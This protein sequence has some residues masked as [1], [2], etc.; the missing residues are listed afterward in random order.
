M[1]HS[2]L[3][4]FDFDGTLYPFAPYDSEE[5]LMLLASRRRGR[6]IQARAKRAVLKDMAGKSPLEEFDRNFLRYAK[7]TDGA[8]LEEDVDII[9]KPCAKEAYASLKTLSEHA[10]IIVLSAGTTDLSRLFLKRFDV[11]QCITGYYGKHLLFDENGKM[12]GYTSEVP[13]TKAKADILKAFRPSY[14]KILA[15]GD[16]LTDKYMLKEA[17]L[18]ILLRYDGKAIFPGFPLTRSIPETV[19]MMINSL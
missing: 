19:Q 12:Y 14:T 18:G 9:I 8:L 10:D 4:A 17:D 11:D 2:T 5:L 1:H 7:G 6:L 15:C 16:G 3:A 13:T